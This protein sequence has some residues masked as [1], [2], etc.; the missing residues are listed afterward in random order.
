VALWI[1]TPFS[2]IMFTNESKEYASSVFSA[3]VTL[4]LDDGGRRF[5]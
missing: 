1:M 5:L 2:L 4:K 3:K